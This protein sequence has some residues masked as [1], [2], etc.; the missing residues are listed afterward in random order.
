[1]LRPSLALL[2]AA[3][4]PSLSPSG[5]QVPDINLELTVLG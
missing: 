2:V 4:A 3:C 5:D 1:M